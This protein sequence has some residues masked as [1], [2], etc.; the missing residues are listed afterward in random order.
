MEDF[1]H[2]GMCFVQNDAF[3]SVEEEEEEEEEETEK[4][5]CAFELSFKVT[6]TMRFDGGRRKRRKF[7]ILVCHR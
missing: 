3:Y 5:E 6:K 4:T 1:L 7:C 2:L